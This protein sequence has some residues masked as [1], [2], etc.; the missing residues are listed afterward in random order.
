MN[1]FALLGGLLAIVYIL[2]ARGELFLT[3]RTTGELPD[4]AQNVARSLWLPGA[5]VML[6]FAVWGRFET[7]LFAGFGV[8]PG[9]LPFI[10]AA[11][12]V[13]AYV[14]MKLKKDGWAFTATSF[15]IIMA[16][17]VEP[18]GGAVTVNNKS[19]HE[20]PAELWRRQVAFVSQHPHFFEGSVLD[21]LRAACGGAMLEKVRAAARLAE[22][23]EFVM[24]LPQR[25][26][27][28]MSEAAARFS[29]G[30]RQRLA[31]TRAF[32]KESTLLLFD[33]PPHTSMWR[34][35]QRCTARFC[36]WP[37]TGR[38]W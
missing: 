35:R 24:A 16:T 31:I 22:A 13:A 2:L 11:A 15:T 27:T 10:T 36:A 26:D 21:N 37:L 9:T 38:Y 1:P 12:F 34:L 3:L 18:T 23:D 19:L 30:E 20:I 32:L 8:V 7:S 14:L 17:I 33:E 6:L 28:P 5:V 4:R 29:G 25:Y